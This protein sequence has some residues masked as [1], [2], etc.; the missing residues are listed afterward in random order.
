M[1]ESLTF[2]D[3]SIIPQYS[4]IKSRLDVNTS[5]SLDRFNLENP[6]ISANMDCVTD[7]KMAI[8]MR[9]LGGIGIL[10]RFYKSEQDRKMDIHAYFSEMHELPIFSIG[11]SEDE[12]NFAIWVSTMYNMPIHVCVDIAHGHSI[13]MAECIH[14]L[15]ANLLHGSYIIA[16]NV[17]T[18]EGAEFLVNLGVDAIKV[19]IGP[20]SNCKTRI[21]TGHGIPQI[22]AIRRCKQAVVGTK[23]KLIAD[24]G[25]T[26]S[27]D[28]CKAIACGADFVMI[29][30]L[31][32]GC[33]ESAAPYLQ[34]TRTVPYYTNGIKYDGYFDVDDIE[35][36]VYRGQSSHE[37]Q[38]DMG[39]YRP[40]IASEGISTKILATGPLENTLNELVGG[41]RSGMTYSGTRTLKEFQSKA[42]WA[43]VTYNGYKE[44]TPHG[45]N[46]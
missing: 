8:A 6:I 45:K 35:Y 14:K 33:N 31:L 28:I 38:M 27:G 22:S 12:I 5:I 21:V 36:K 18:Y 39:T 25:I 15:K 24:G 32:A 3:I 17:C 40:T 20:G 10:H 26:N 11:V 29:G 44:G 37:I 41:L 4:D 30:R 42:R 16:G 23:V 7:A 46:N 43:L 13:L 19:G 2:N 9:K 34:I 1:D